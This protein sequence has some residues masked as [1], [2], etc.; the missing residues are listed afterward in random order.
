M[1][2]ILN[3]LQKIDPQWNDMQEELLMSILSNTTELN[4]CCKH[5]ELNSIACVVEDMTEQVLF[6]C[7][8]KKLHR[9]NII[10]KLFGASPLSKNIHHRKGSSTLKDLACHVVSSYPLLVLQVIYAKAVHVSAKKGF[11]ENVTVTMEAYIP[12]LNDTAPLFSYPAV[13]QLNG[14]LQPHAIDYTHILTNICSIILH[15]RFRNIKPEAFF[16]IS[17]DDSSILSKAL[18]KDIFDKQSAD[19]ALHLFSEQVELKLIENGDY[20]QALFVRI[21]RNWHDACD[22][23]WVSADDRV[24]TLWAMNTYLTKD[25]DWDYFPAPGAY[26]KSI[27]ILTFGAMLHLNSTCIQLYDISEKKT[28]NARTISTLDCENMFSTVTSNDPQ[29]Q[30][31]PKAAEIP[32]LM[33][34]LQTIE[35]YINSTER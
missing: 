5:Q 27:P 16:R 3:D 6:N 8:S 25:V 23:H 13:N 15:H 31:C 11:F 29:K 7:S 2:E 32:C 18:T 34:T 28:Y 10:G 26:I 24:N 14:N 1:K 17:D 9:V 20:E 33:A 35:R 22:K 19:V 12:L 21:M 4:K 30:G